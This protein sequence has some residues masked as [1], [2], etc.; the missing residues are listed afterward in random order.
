KAL[1]V[2]DTSIG[3][4]LAIAKL[5]AA[6]PGKRINQVIA[7]R[8][9]LWERLLRP[10]LLAALNTEPEI[11]SARLAAAVLRETLMKGG[12]AYRPRIASPHL[13]NTFIDPALDYLKRNGAEVR[14]GR[15]LRR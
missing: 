11:A 15:R 7:C 2:P 13:G 10:L 6:P 12:R 8:G 1:R 14:F 3:E 5:L 4:Y 9:N